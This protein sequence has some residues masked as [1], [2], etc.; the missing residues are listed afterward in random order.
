MY[1]IVMKELWGGI[2]KENSKII[3]EMANATKWS[4]LSEIIA[5]LIIPI[6]NMVL[7]RILSPEIF[8]VVATITM[9]TSFADMLTDAG[10]QKYLIQHQFESKK[11][12]FDNANVAFITNLILSC[13]I[14]IIIAIFNNPIAKL[15][16]NDGFGFALCIASLQLPVTAL[17]SIQMAIYKKNL[18]FKTLFI[19]R[20]ISILLPFLITIPL[21]ILGF[22]H[23]ALIIGTLLG[24]C[25]NA[26]IL[27]IYSEWK[28]NKFFKYSIL[29]NMFSFSSWTLIESLTI[30]LSG[31]IDTFIIGTIMSSYYL[32]LYKNSINMINSIMSL[33]T[34][35]I[36]PVLLSGISKLKNDNDRYNEVFFNAQR[37][38]AWI[39]FPLGIGI[40]LYRDLVVNI[41][42]GNKWMEAANIIGV[43]ALVIPFKISISSLVSICYISKGKANISAL[44]QML[45][46]IPLIPISVLA[47]KMGFWEFVYIRNLFIFEL[48]IVN[49]IFLN[50]I[51]K[52]SAFRMCANIIKPMICSLG[53]ILMYLLIK[54]I[55]TSFIGQFISIFICG[56]TYIAIMRIIAK[57]EIDSIIKMIKVTSLKNI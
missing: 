50:Y 8:G 15:L 37:I 20:I 33:I 45:Y 21:A 55:F 31:N 53:M 3:S 32:G 7:S 39:V 11:E 16:G 52:I 1:Q 24:N 28:P 19:R 29:K 22:K 27:T 47:L 43:A 49:L 4:V 40:F 56:F 41:L 13:L 54:N 12:L 36:I 35:S 34:M 18:D 10:F 2:L 38:V 23:W 14:W 30:W 26:L 6:T 17:S 51:M 25:T 57:K 44:S 48:I 42:F 9:I 5:K 46:I